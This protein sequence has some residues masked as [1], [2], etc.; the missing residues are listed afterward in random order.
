MGYNIKIVE[1]DALHPIQAAG[2]TLIKQR[3]HCK[4]SAADV[5]NYQLKCH[6]ISPAVSIKQFVKDN[7][8]GTGI[9]EKAFGTHWTKSRLKDLLAEGTPFEFAKLALEKCV[10]RVKKNVTEQTVPASDC[11]RHMTEA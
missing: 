7:L 10:E 6:Q 11:L 4:H 2:A 3:K 5:M 1:D 9:P 8:T